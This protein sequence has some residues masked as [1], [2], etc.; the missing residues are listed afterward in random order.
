MAGGSGGYSSPSGSTVA[1]RL[2]AARASSDENDYDVE[3]NRLLQDALQEFN[4]RDA[5][6]D[7]VRLDAITA[8]IGEEGDDAL[9]LR[10]GGSVSKHTHVDGL[11]DVDVL[12][13][14]NGS[15]LAGNSPAE[16][17]EHF[18]TRLR[19][20]LSGAQVDVG[21]LAVTIR[22]PDGREIQVLPAL[23]TKGGLRIAR[24]DGDGWSPVVRP[25]AFARKLTAVN[26]ANGDRVVPVIKLF[27]AMAEQVLPANSRLS[28]YHAES[29]AI[30]AFERYDGPLTPKVMLRHLAGVAVDRVLDPIRDATGQSLHVDEHLG[31]AGSP[32]RRDLSIRLGRLA[33]RIDDAERRMDAD[34]WNGMIG[35]GG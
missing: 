1:Q 22:Y 20:R 35:E 32:A 2:A 14:L 25:D 10:F 8:A 31:G 34:A 15:E 5:A 16:V 7:R 12:A 19:G 30:E 28:G 29:L 27:K 13:V 4:D 33:K 6:A 26:Q 9:T 3:V 23:A 24:P 18:A 17:I 21:N 11:S